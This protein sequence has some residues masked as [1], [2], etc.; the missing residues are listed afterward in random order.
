MA[1]AVVEGGCLCGAIRYV[2]RAAPTA[3]LDE[4]AAAPATHHA[5]VGDGVRW[6]RFADGLPAFERN[7]AEG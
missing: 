4:P 5:W 1:D 6:M 3:S 2:A 7:A